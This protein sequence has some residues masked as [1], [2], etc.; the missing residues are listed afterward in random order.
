M[1]IKDDFIFVEHILDSIKAI[2]EFTRNSLYVT[3]M[4]ALQD[5]R[6]RYQV[7]AVYIKNG[8][9]LFPTQ[10]CEELLQ[11]LFYLGSESLDDLLDARVYLILGVMHTGE[12][13]RPEIRWL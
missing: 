5:K 3:P 12:V 8:I 9:V 7:A 1:K 13:D 11:Q 2:E 4:Q 10:G 6:S